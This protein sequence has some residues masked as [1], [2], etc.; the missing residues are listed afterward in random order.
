MTEAYMPCNI[1]TFARAIYKK[2]CDYFGADHESYCVEALKT[3]LQSMEDHIESQ[4]KQIA[5]LEIYEN[6]VSTTAS[7]NVEVM[8]KNNELQAVVDKFIIPVKSTSNDPV[9]W[10]LVG[11]IEFAVEYAARKKR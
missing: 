8:K 6:L 4:D 11:A 10:D 9:V 7:L 5:E 1:D 2:Q 3:A